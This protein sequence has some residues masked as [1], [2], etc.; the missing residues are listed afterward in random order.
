MLTNLPKNNYVQKVSSLS[1]A[2]CY[3]YA[4]YLFNLFT[5]ASIDEKHYRD[6]ADTILDIALEIGAQDTLDA[7]L[8]KENN[9]LQEANR[10]GS[11]D[12]VYKV[13]GLPNDCSDTELRF[14]RCVQYGNPDFLIRILKN[15]I[16]KKTSRISSYM[17][18]LKKVS[19]INTHFDFTEQELQVLLYL[20]RLNTWAYF[21]PRLNKT[22]IKDA[23]VLFQYLTGFNAQQ[24]TTA[25]RIDKKLRQYGFTNA[26]GLM[27]RELLKCIAEQ[28]MDAFFSDLMPA[29]P[30][31]E[32]WNLSD[33]PIPNHVSSLMTSLLSG[34]APVSLLFYGPHDSGKTEYCKSLVKAAGK[35]LFIFK[36]EDESSN[37]DATLAKLKNLL[38]IKQSDSIIIVDDADCL[39]RTADDSP[40]ARNASI[41]TRRLINKL[42]DNNKTKV[43]FIINSTD[44]MNENTRR[45][46]SFS[47]GFN[48]LSEKKLQAATAR[49]LEGTEL[50][51]LVKKRLQKLFNKYRIPSKSVDTVIRTIQSIG[52]SSSEVLVKNAATILQEKSKLM[53]GAPKIRATVNNAYDISVLQTSIDAGRI[54]SMIENARKF[55]E[56]NKC[57]ENGIRMLFY[58]LSG[59]GKT[60][61]ARYIA[62]KLGKK[63]LLKRASDILSRYVGD[64]EKNIANAFAQAAATDQILLFDE[65]DSF[66][67]SRENARYEWERNQVNEI[68]TQM[69]E[70]PG[71]LICTTNLKQ[72]L[73]SATERRFDIICEFKPLEKQG[74]VTLLKK[75]FCAYK[76]TDAQ[77]SRIESYGTITPGDFGAVQ[78]SVRFMAQKDISTDY[79]ISELA[80]RQESKDGAYAGRIGFCA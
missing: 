10:L 29:T 66:F 35:K 48:Q 61:Y 23:A 25:L 21:K 31:N 56:K 51:A 27:A 63:I 20:Y 60:E 64:T 75:Y 77:I 13:F 57:S 76:F 67:S 54:V 2:E 55:S 12:E 36:G 69:E 37:P 68:L 71:I 7:F 50:P 8:A 62:E 24:F 9:R 22:G 46:F 34:D 74:I 3:C 19:F 73:D 70:Y 45:R 28:N 59:T 80:A 15:V 49:K 47:Y 40:A 17:K 18:D 32:A 5:K 58:G 16:L 6:Y 53:Y 41:H 38:E 44:Q 52:D 26:D 43:I 65:C 42:L 30:C 4:Q 78:R 72:I 14:Y 39:F 11:D 1:K 79:I 33:Y